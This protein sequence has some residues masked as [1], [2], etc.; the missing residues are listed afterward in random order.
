[1]PEPKKETGT[2]RVT[3]TIRCPTC[4]R[5]LAREK[6]EDGFFIRLTGARPEPCCMKTATDGHTVA[7]RFVTE[8]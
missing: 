3:G 5:E 2:D 8:P 4:S 6:T 7:G 1:M